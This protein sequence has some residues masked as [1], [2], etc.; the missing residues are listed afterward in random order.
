MLLGEIRIGVVEG[1]LLDA[2]GE[3][4]GVPRDLVRRAHM[5]HGDI[6]DVASLA[7]SRG[8]SA[9]ELINLRLFVPIKPMLAEMADDPQ[10]VLGEHKDGTAFEYK[11]DGS[12]I[13]IHRKDEKVQIFSRR[14]TDVTDSIREIVVFA[15]TQVNASEYLIK[16]EVVEIGASGKPIPFQDL[17]RRFRRVHEIESVEEK[18]PPKPYLC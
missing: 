18:I 6:G 5:L 11:F 14:L 12:R 1:V 2:I 10:Q 9:L 17:M 7:M 4:S 13:Q 8:A 3:A 16:G 15:K